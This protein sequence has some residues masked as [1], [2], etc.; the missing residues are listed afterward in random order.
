MIV[1]ITSASQA[2]DK[3]PKSMCINLKTFIANR[4]HNILRNSTLNFIRNACPSFLLSGWG[5]TL[6]RYDFYLGIFS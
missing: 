2:I 3:S 1:K 5:F 4:M 6:K